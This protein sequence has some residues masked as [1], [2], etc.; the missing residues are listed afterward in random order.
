MRKEDLEKYPL[1]LER[2]YTGSS[3]LWKILEEA[4]RDLLGREIPYGEYKSILNTL[5]CLEVGQI[6]LLHLCLDPDFQI[7][8]GEVATITTGDRIRREVELCIYY[9]HLVVFECTGP[10]QGRAYRLRL[11]GE[12]WRNRKWG[13]VQVSL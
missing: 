13:L 4:S 3:W 6:A 7:V 11:A 8:E 2:T 5:E 1:A 9:H 10:R 12:T